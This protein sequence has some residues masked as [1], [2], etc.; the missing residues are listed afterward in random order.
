MKNY[1]LFLLAALFT[2]TGVN[3]Q[4]NVQLHITHMLGGDAFVQDGTSTNNLDHDFMVTRMDY[5]I[6]E[7]SIVHDGG[8]ETVV[9]DLWILVKAAAESVTEIDLG[10][11]EITEVE[12]VN[13]YI[14]VDPDHNH[15]DP[16]SW[17]E[18]HPLAPQHPSMHWGWNSGYRFIAFEGEGG[19]NYNQG[20][21]LHGLGDENYFRIELP[22][23]S[24]PVDGQI[25]MNIAGDYSRVIENIEVNSGV[26][27][28]GDYGAAQKALENCRDFVFSAT[29][30]STVSIDEVNSFEVFPNPAMDGKTAFVVSSDENHTYEVIITDLLGRQVQHFKTVNSNEKVEVEL[31]NSGLYNISL[32]KAGQP[33]LT[34]RLIVK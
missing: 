4:N 32:I 18:T 17:P 34:E 20:I 10:D 21:E 9:E 8:T 7:I 22:L 6:S 23:S 16:A 24:M 2:C 30:T 19:S 33:V 1:I 11:H 26:L 27:V 5:Y 14:G 15:L 12:G 13:F 25:T 28:H 29:T 31:F 3:A